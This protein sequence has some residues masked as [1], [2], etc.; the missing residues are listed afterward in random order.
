MPDIEI[1][2]VAGGSARLRG[3]LAVPEGDG[4]WPGVVAIHEALGLNDILRRQ[5]DRLARA[6]YLT[7]APDL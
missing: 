4:P 2:P 7:L 5:V 6:G 1:G 3:Y